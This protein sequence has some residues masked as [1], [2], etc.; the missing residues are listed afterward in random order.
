MIAEQS[1]DHQSITT[2]QPLTLSNLYVPN[3]LISGLNSG[4][5]FSVRAA[6]VVGSIR[7]GGRRAQRG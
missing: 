6:D 5:D 1:A 2:A 4:L 3:T 7:L